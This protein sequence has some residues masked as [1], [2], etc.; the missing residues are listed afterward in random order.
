MTFATDLRLA[1]GLQADRVGAWLL[2]QFGDVAGELTRPR[3]GDSPYPYFAR[4][5]AQAPLVRSKAGLWTTARHGTA[6]SILRDRRFGVRDSNNRSSAGAI[7]TALEGLD[8]DPFMG[9]DPP[10]HTRMRSLMNPTFSPSANTMYRPRIE[11]IVDEVLDK[12]ARQGSFDLV[13][14][15]AQPVPL[16]VIADVLGVPEQY[17][18]RL[19]ECAMRVGLVTDQLNGVAKIRELRALLIELKELFA[20]LLE[21]RRAEGIDE[22]PTDMI[23]SL[24]LA[25][26]KQEVPVSE[27]QA[28]L[29]TA[30]IAGSENSVNVMGNAVNALLDHPEQWARLIAEPE[31]SGNA[32]EETMRYDSATLMVPRITHQEV[33]I[34][35]HLLPADTPVLVLLAAANHD[36][37]VFEE[38][39][40][41]DITRANAAEHL[42]FTAGRYFCI[43][44]P[45]SRVE[46]EIALRALV[47]RMP[48]LRRTGEPV[49]RRSAAFRGLTGMPVAA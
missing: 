16:L 2:R 48:N 37:S 29:V 33:D 26:T 30:L 1:A 28:L 40:R 15:F 7:A 23:G 12:A 35:G 8:L 42:T 18:Q 21:Q 22:A 25:S 13:R 19:G 43:G 17:R 44:A 46:G 10:V 11:R 24:L 36:P 34:E 31:L 3:A 49:F 39:E 32:L 27:M 5:R 14:D 38:P 4:L 6:N 9:V 47:E 45:L 20:T 41:F